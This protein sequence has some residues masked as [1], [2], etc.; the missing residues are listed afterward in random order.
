M[1]FSLSQISRNDCMGMG[2]RMERDSLLG[3]MS[4]SVVPSRTSAT[5]LSK[6]NITFFFGSKAFFEDA[7]K[8][9]NKFSRDRP[10]HVCSRQT[11]SASARWRTSS[12]FMMSGNLL[13][14][15]ELRKW[16]RRLGTWP[17]ACKNCTIDRESSSF[18]VSSRCSPW[19]SRS[20]LRI[21]VS[22]TSAM[23]IWAYVF[24]KVLPVSLS[25]STSLPRSCI[26]LESTFSV[27]PSP[28]L[29]M[30]EI[31]WMTMPISS[32]SICSTG[33]VTMQSITAILISS[34]GT[35]SK[36][37]STCSRWWVPIAS[38]TCI[39]ARS[40]GPCFCAKKPMRW[41]IP[42]KALQTES[43]LMCVKGGISML[44]SSPSWGD[45]LSSLSA[46]IANL[47]RSA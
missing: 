22:Y 6:R 14:I 20:E 33:I 19:V 37:S 43:L 30:S 36:C 3:L 35:S 31:A 7:F 21:K 39:L 5:R 8:H 1:R 44:S 27:C 41:M 12:F 32:V 15:S 23:A 38:L 40:S 17:Q 9:S 26:S 4:A 28:M 29:R 46:L 45:V 47:N 34:L 10:I 13:L 16:R 25:S 11:S 18:C 2:L 42:K 24:L